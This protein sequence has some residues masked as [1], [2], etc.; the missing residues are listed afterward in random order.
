MQYTAQ[1]KLLVI[2]YCRD[3]LA[4]K[5]IPLLSVSGTTTKPRYLEVMGIFVVFLLLPS[6]NFSLFL[7]G[8]DCTLQSVSG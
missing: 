7:G 3:G 5:L 2:S 6:I 1:N 4:E 8:V